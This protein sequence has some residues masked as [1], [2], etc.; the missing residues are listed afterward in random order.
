MLSVTGCIPPF[1]IYPSSNAIRPLEEIRKS[2]RRPVVVFPECTTSNGRALLRFAH[3]FGES[4][5]SIPVR[6]Y[7]IFI[8][9]VRYVRLISTK[10][11]RQSTPVAQIRCP[12]SRFAHSHSVTPTLSH[13]RIPKHHGSP[14]LNVSYAV[15]THFHPSLTAIRISQ[16]CD[17]CALRCSVG[18]W[19]GHASRSMR[20]SRRRFRQI[21]AHTVGM[22]REV[23]FDGFALRQ[24]KHKSTNSIG[25]NG[26][27][28]Q[29]K[30]RD[31]LREQALSTNGRWGSNSTQRHFPAHK[32]TSGILH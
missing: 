7:S 22:G 17:V 27:T 21:K 19:A 5:P 4:P 11:P 1:G 13:A 20:G 6:P 2:A 8:M 16:R 12:H 30:S 32:Q 28:K 15:T 9:C 24:T 18:K 23:W 31:V 25:V 10:I 29:L 26:E 14:I 3:I